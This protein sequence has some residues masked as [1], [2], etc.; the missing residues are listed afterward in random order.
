MKFLRKFYEWVLHWAYTSYAVP[1]LFVLSFAESAFLP[2]MPEVILFPLCLS[3]HK[4]AFYYAFVCSI[5]SVL[6]GLFGYLIGL[7]FWS[8]GQKIVFHYMTPEKFESVRLTYHNHEAWVIFMAA[9]TPVPYKIFT[10]AAGFF[11]GDLAVFTIASILGRSAKFF[12]I[13]APFYFFGPGIKSKIEKYFHIIGVFVII[14]VVIII[15]I[16]KLVKR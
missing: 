5:S 7:E 10:I 4:K 8:I 3:R 13:V 11:R 9:L 14:V 16:I 2:I 12:M 15:L 1:A 6:G